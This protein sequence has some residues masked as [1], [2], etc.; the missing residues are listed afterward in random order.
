MAGYYLYTLYREPEHEMVLYR[1]TG[2]QFLGAIG[3][4]DDAKYWSNRVLAGKFKNWTLV[5]ERRA[6]VENKEDMYYEL[7]RTTGGYWGPKTGRL[8]GECRLWEKGERRTY[9]GQQMGLCTKRNEMTGRCTWCPES[10]GEE[11]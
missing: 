7:P 1:G 8:C 5:K 11:Q 2:E 9:D 4:P 6:V 3:K 10:K